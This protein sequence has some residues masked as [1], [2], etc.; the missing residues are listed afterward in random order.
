LDH[1]LLIHDVHPFI[2]QGQNARAG[3][4]AV[5]ARRT[6]YLYFRP[7]EKNMERTSAG[8]S[9]LENSK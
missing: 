6:I 1:S 2:E 4:F 9:E 8:Y 3:G 5:F 7:E